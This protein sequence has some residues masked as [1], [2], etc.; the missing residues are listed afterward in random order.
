MSSAGASLHSETAQ[1]RSSHTAAYELNR[2]RVFIFPTRFG[3]SFFAVLMVMLIG[4]INYNNNLGFL[5]TF[6]LGSLALVAILHTYRNLAGLKL[7][8]RGARSVFAGQATKF[9]L[10][11]DNLAGAERIGINVTFAAEP[12]EVSPRSN[13]ATTNVPSA[14]SQTVDLGVQTTHRGSL[15]LGQIVVASHYP[16]GLFRAWANYDANVSATVFPRLQGNRELPFDTAHAIS[17]SG[18]H[19]HGTDDFIGLR[20]Y[21]PGDSSRRIHWKAVARDQQTTVKQFSGSAPRE[22]TLNWVETPQTTLEPRLSQLALWI[23]EAQVQGLTFSLV[24]PNESFRPAQGESHRQR[25]LHALAHYGVIND[26][27]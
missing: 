9:M 1:P 20:N 24:L 18:A 13:L 23:V 14:G 17:N 2:R 10:Q 22:V 21:I 11:L 8:V 6:L 4:S 16:L 26:A 12:Q 5:L 25:C 7:R 27:H 19:S 3:L 15:E